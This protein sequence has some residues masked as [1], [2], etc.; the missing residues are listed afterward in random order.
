M[1]CY[2]H[3]SIIYLLLYRSFDHLPYLY[4]DRSITC[5]PAWVTI[6]PD[7]LYYAICT[8]PWWLCAQTPSYLCY[9][10]VLR[11]HLTC[12]ISI[13]PDIQFYAKLHASLPWWL[14]AQTPSYLCHYYKA[15]NTMLSY[16][17]R[18]HEDY[19]LRHHPTWVITMH[20]YHDDYLLRHHLTCVITPWPAT[21][22]GSD[23][24]DEYITCS[25]Y[26]M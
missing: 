11:H 25:R 13:Q 22:S 21:I 18:F 12:G 14:C 3:R 20:C 19:V 17:H 16:M 24:Q 9:Y 5:L 26:V 23:E 4:I 15:W 10:Y 2:M 1:L 6:L 7:I 8:L